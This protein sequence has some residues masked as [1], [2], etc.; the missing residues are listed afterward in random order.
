M[1]NI[2]T[3]CGASG[4]PQY[5]ATKAYMPKDPDE[6]S[7]K[8]AE[9][10]IV[11][12]QEEGEALHAHNNAVL[13]SIVQIWT[14]N[15]LFSCQSGAMGRE[16]EMENGAGFLP[17]VPQRS[18]TPPPSKTTCS[19]WSACAKRPTSEPGSSISEGLA[20]LGDGGAAHEHKGQK[21]LLWSFF[22]PRVP[23]VQN[24]SSERQ[25]R[26]TDCLGYI[27]GSWCEG[28]F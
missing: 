11:L 27:H 18:P 8:Q 21:M 24:S 28:N 12:Q 2:W 7:L 14:S 13:L 5:E 15:V 20:S 23:S 22:W 6:L 25:P 17:A 9:L 1:V 10:V 19:A 16:W 3:C 4:L 26:G